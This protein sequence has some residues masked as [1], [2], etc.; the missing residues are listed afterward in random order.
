MMRALEE[1]ERRLGY[2]FRARKLLE[3]ALTHRSAVARCGGNNEKLEFLGDAVLD[4][5]ISEL[6][7]ERF[8]EATEGDLSKVRAALVNATML[9]AKATDL[10]LGAWL[11]LGRGEERSGGRRKGSILASAC[12][13]VFGAVFLDGGF[14]AARGVVARLFAAE[15][16]RPL[17]SH[18]TDHKTR[19]QEVTQRRFR[20]TPV[21][22]LVQASGPDHDKAF[23]A[24]IRIGG[25]L[26]GRGEGK[27]K[28]AAEQRA[29]LEALETLERELAE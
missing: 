22:Q 29:A 7:M 19:L 13:A 12:E 15:L 8:P 2:A 26:Y 24:E 3:T 16:E 25:R 9:A 21:Y 11:R 28:K 4:L 6:L 14:E 17:R 27:S 23:V 10:D 5:A 1:L 20:E 18:L